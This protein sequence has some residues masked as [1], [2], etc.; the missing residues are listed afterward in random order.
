MYTGK[1]RWGEGKKQTN[2][3]TN[4]GKTRPWYLA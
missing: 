1:G 4:G 3:Q 2:K